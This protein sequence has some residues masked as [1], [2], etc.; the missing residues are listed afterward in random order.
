VIRGEY[1]L[2]EAPEQ[3]HHRQIDLTMSAIRRGIDQAG[4]AAPVDVQVSAQRSP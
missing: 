1:A 2:R 3:P 4:L